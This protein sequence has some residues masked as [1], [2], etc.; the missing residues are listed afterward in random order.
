MLESARRRFANESHDLNGRIEAWSEL[1][2]P[3]TTFG[4]PPTGYEFPL[5]GFGFPVTAGGEEGAP[6]PTPYRPEVHGPI[7]LRLVADPDRYPYEPWMVR[8]RSRRGVGVFNPHVSGEGPYAGSVCWVE[9]SEAFRP[10]E[11]P[12]GAVLEH[13]LRILA[14]ESVNIEGFALNEAAKDWFAENLSRLPFAQV[15]LPAWEAAAVAAPP[16][17]SRLEIDFGDAEALP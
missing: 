6:R 13:V 1:I 11:W 16:R 2:G 7:S 9:Q 8:I 5:K 10:A 4:V 3:P 17:P 15:P 12:A 14:G